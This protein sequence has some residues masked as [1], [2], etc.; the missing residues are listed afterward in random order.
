MQRYYRWIP[1]LVAALTNALIAYLVATYQPYPGAALI[2]QTVIQLAALLAVFSSRVMAALSLIL[3]LGGMAA[4]LSFWFYWVPTLVAVSVALS[5]PRSP[6][7]LTHD[8]LA[9]P[10]Q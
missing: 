3:L 7:L 2:A 10:H 9:E 5:R 1:S 6:R 8:N 4:M